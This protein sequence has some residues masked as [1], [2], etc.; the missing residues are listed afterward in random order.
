MV[1]LASPQTFN[2]LLTAI[3]QEITKR[4]E[5]VTGVRFAYIGAVQHT[6]QGVVHLHQVTPARLALEFAGGCPPSNGGPATRDPLSPRKVFEAWWQSQ[7]R[8][9]FWD[10]DEHC[11]HTTWPGDRHWQTG[12]LLAASGGNSVRAA[13]RGPYGRK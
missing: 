13:L 9:Y 11:I 4:W 8:S 5:R 3:W 6:Q 10:A 7:I 2:V 12:R 1:Q